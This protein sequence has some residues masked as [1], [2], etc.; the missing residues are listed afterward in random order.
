MTTLERLAVVVADAAAE[1]FAAAFEST[2]LAV[3]MFRDDAT[4]LWTIEAV[5]YPGDL[6]PVTA[7]LALAALASGID[8][9][10]LTREAV[11]AEGWLA[12]VARNFPPQPI[13]RTWLVV[14]THDRDTPAQGRRR[15]VLDAG[16]AF[17]SGEHGST[18]GCLRAI[19][20]MHRPRGTILDLGTGSGILAIAA[21]RH[22]RRL[23]LATDIDPTSVLV[24]ACN[25]R[26]NGVPH[27][28]RTARSN[29]WSAAAIRR[30]QPY[31]LVLANILA[32]PLCA[33]ARD[34]ARNLAP[35]GHAVLAGLLDTQARQVFW[36]HRRQGLVLARRYR[37]A[38][39]TTLVLTKKA[40]AKKGTVP[41]HRPLSA[42]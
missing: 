10:T 22:W 40:L 36:A 23:V 42:G 38:R 11:A 37:E 15:L 29:G 16:L 41:K 5:R 12:Q 25:A 28:V 17:G 2:C 14:G 4:E 30:R 20:A 26:D 3:G 35:G 13:G 21:A 33:M 31:A 1:P 19:E 34:L 6:A 18:R 39:W 7:A 9:P 32:R 24:A 8:A 27:L